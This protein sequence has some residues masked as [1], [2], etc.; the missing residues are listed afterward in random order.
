MLKLSSVLDLCY[1]KTHIQK[2]RGWYL[3]FHLINID[4]LR[5]SAQSLRLLNTDVS[6]LTTRVASNVIGDRA[7]IQILSRWSFL[8]GDALSSQ[9][10][11]IFKQPSCMNDLKKQNSDCRETYANLDSMSQR[12]IVR[13]NR[14]C[15]HHQAREA[16]H[17]R[18]WNETDSVT[19]EFFQLVLVWDDDKQS[20]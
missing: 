13:I 20:F 19:I 6:R 14:S 4:A 3:L 9:R 18:A 7:M 8:G 15:L 1:N 16:S 5:S 11:M 2:T 12:L 10:G 17:N